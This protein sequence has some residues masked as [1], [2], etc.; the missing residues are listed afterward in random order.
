MTKDPQICRPRVKAEF[1]ASV[2][3]WLLPGKE[4]D[5]G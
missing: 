1:P 4:R 2:G 3:I 5:A